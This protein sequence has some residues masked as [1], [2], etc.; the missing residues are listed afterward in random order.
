MS[1]IQRK[2]LADAAGVDLATMQS[3]VA[4]RDKEL[5]L[6]GQQESKMEGILAIASGIV[7]FGKENIGV[8]TTGLNWLASLSQMKALGWIKEKAHMLWNWAFSKKSHMDRMRQLVKERAAKRASAAADAATGGAGSIPAGPKGGAGGGMMKSMGKIKPSSVLKG[9]AAMVLAAAAIFVFA[10]ALQEM[11]GI[12]L[13]EVLVAA[14]SVA[15]MMGAMLLIGLM[16]QGPLGAMMLTGAF[17]MLVIAAAVY[18][19]GKALQE[20]ATGFDMMSGMTEQL[21][22]LVALAPSMLLAAA[23]FIAM[24][25]GLIALSAGLLLLAPMLPIILALGGLAAVGM[26]LMGGG[27]GGGD[28]SSNV[29]AEKLDILIDLISQGGTVKMDGHKVGEVI[30]LARGPMGT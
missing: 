10:K 11:K 1:V 22:G 24:G 30:A 4:N 23:G 28:D 5:N 9:A 27:E 15:I 18:V 26:N 6:T 17:A 12:G 14:A 29:I 13:N 8:V 20:M 16:M 25:Y 21:T 3:M 2:A 7:S 19:L